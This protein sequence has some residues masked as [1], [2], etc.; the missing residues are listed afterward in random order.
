MLFFWSIVDDDV[1]LFGG[2]DVA[3]IKK[4]FLP[5]I[6]AIYDWCSPLIQWLI[7]IL[8][9]L[10][11]CVYLVVFFFLF[12]HRKTNHTHTVH[13]SWWQSAEHCV[14][15]CVCLY[16]PRSGN[17]TTWQNYL[18]TT[19]NLFLFISNKL[20]IWCIFFIWFHDIQLMWDTFVFQIIFLIGGHRAPYELDKRHR[21]HTLTYAHL[22][23]RPAAHEAPPII[24]L[25]FFFCDV[26]FLSLFHFFFFFKFTRRKKTFCWFFVF[27]F[28]FFFVCYF[29]FLE[30]EVH[31]YEAKYFHQANLLR[32]SWSIDWGLIVSRWFRFHADA[33]LFTIFGL[34]RRTTTDWTGATT[35]TTTTSRTTNWRCTMHKCILSRWHS[36]INR[37]QALCFSKWGDFVIRRESLKCCILQNYREREN[38]KWKERID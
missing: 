37:I 24:L 5:L 8:N 17:K 14:Y 22:F 6:E 13:E 10:F 1:K 26:F 12:T 18:A 25:V 33:T 34:A 15:V 9:L 30:Q 28:N 27:C 11:C 32:L 19:T 7:I 4:S 23:V 35:T 29:L 31:W 21:K 38:K 2:D 3:T 16:D 36:F 20:T